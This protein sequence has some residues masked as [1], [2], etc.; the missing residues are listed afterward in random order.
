[1][2][3]S[4]GSLVNYLIALGLLD[5]MPRLA[6]QLAALG[7]IAAATVVNFIALKYIVLERRHYRPL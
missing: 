4:V 2:S 7:G 6:P 5:R 1:M 3:V